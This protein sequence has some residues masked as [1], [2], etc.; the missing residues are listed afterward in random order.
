MNFPQ[1]SLR[2]IVPI[3]VEYEAG[4]Q[5]LFNEMTLVTITYN[6][7]KVL[8][9]HIESLRNSA[10]KKLPRW[11]VVDN[12]STDGSDELLERYGQDIE[13][14]K[15][16]EN[17]G[18]GSACNFG[19]SA[20]TTRYVLVL[21]PDTQLAELELEKL[22]AELKLHGAAIAGPALGPTQDQ[23]VEAADWLVG[24]VLLFDTEQMAAVG[25]F[26]EQF[27]LYGEDVDICKRANNAGLTVIHCRNVSIP[28]V[29]GGSTVRSKRVN[30]FIH[31]HKGRSFVLYAQKHGLPNNVVEKYIADNRRRKIIAVFTFG[32]GRYLRASAKLKGVAS[33]LAEAK[34][35][36]KPIEH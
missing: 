2:N 19:I 17:L 35:T 14:L 26:D 23:R 12:A 9:A 5:D 11:L 16:T 27:F 20:S 33:V 1:N 15:N 24:A 7:A 34:K 32:G 10:N 25:Y 31:F 36:D 6:S 18:F 28:H 3:N 13:L 30:Q 22:L 4:M 29:G 8:P 21:N